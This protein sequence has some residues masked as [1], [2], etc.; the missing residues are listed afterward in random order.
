MN[1][2]IGDYVWYWNWDKKKVMKGVVDHTNDVYSISK[3]VQKEL[4]LTNGTVWLYSTRNKNGK[5]VRHAV[6]YGKFSIENPWG[7]KQISIKSLQNQIWCKRELWVKGMTCG[8]AVEVDEECWLTKEEAEKDLKD[9]L[10]RK[11]KNEQK[12]IKR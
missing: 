9:L 8:H 11:S 5:L 2:N 6:G 1:V 4:S 3:K 7:F 12:N 10:E